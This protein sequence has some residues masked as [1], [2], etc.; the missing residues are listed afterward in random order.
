MSEKRPKVSD[1]TDAQR[2]A[3]KEVIRAALKAAAHCMM[4]FLQGSGKWPLDDNQAMSIEDTCTAYSVFMTYHKASCQSVNNSGRIREQFSEGKQATIGDYSVPW[5]NLKNYFDGVLAIYGLNYNNPKV[6]SCDNWISISSAYLNCFLAFKHRLNEVHLGR[7]KW[8]I[9]MNGTTPAYRELSH[10]GMSPQHSPLCEGITF[11]PYM[12]S[13]LIGSLGPG[14]LFAY[15]M[16]NKDKPEIK[17]R[18]KA[19]R[20]IL[21]SLSSIPAITDIMNVI[22]ESTTAVARGVIG[23]VMDFLLVAGFRTKNRAYFPPAVLLSDTK[24]KPMEKGADNIFSLISGGGS[25]Q[26]PANVKSMD[27]TGAGMWRLY[28]SMPKMSMKVGSHGDQILSHAILGTDKDDLGVLE[29]ATGVQWVNRNTIAKALSARSTKPSVEVKAV[30]F[31]Y[32]CKMAT[33]NT[34]PGL[35]P[36]RTTKSSVVTLGGKRKAHVSGELED[37]I[38]SLNS[39]RAVSSLGNS[40]AVIQYLNNEAEGA[41]RFLKEFGQRGTNAWYRIDPVTK[42]Y[43]DPFTNTVAIAEDF[44]PEETGQYFH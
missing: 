31:M 13:S 42:T 26:L 40:T 30:P 34:L 28:H 19:K 41:M 20:E 17:F 27:L 15:Y 2:A 7:T 33:A 23:A 32:V 14:A 39:N 10:Y 3:Q 24:F 37:Y 38:L 4:V 16:D 44:M 35:Y 9:G 18:A 22:E 5:P 8:Q 25:L 12:K 11:P 1:L 21:H 43:V 6:G 29:R 36:N